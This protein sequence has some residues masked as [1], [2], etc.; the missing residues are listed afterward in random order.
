MK[1]IAE[2]KCYTEEKMELGW[3]Y[4]VVSQSEFNSWTD[5]SAGQTV[6]ME[7]SGPGFKLYPGQISIATSKNPLVLNTI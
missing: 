3:Q 1:T 7:F 4:K 2:I 6:S 5:S